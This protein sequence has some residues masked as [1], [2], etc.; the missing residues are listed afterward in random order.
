MF[1]PFSL[2]TTPRPFYH[3]F[4]RNYCTYSAK[5]LTLFLF[6]AFICFNLFSYLYFSSLAFI[7]TDLL[8]GSSNLPGFEDQS[9]DRREASPLTES[10]TWR[11]FRNAPEWITAWFHAQTLGPE[12]NASS[13][14]G[15]QD[16]Q[17]DVV[18]TWVNGS[19][20]KL[21]TLKDKYQN[22]SPFFQQYHL[23][24]RRDTLSG[25]DILEQSKR[26]TETPS[27]ATSSSSS[28]S[29]ASER[30]ND[31]RSRR[32]KRGVKLWGR[33]DQTANR[34]RDMDELKY[35]VR[36]VSQYA[37]GMFNKIHILTT[38]VDPE[39][40]ENQIPTWLDLTRSKEAIQL[41]PHT[42]IFDD[43]QV[44]PSFN[45]LSIE[46]QIHHTPGVTDV[47]L[48]L[49][50]DV[51]LGRTMAAA[52][53]WT[54]LYG[55]V[56]HM[57]PSLLVPP[58]IL[59]LDRTSLSVGEWNSLQYS[60]FLLSKQ[61]GFRH[62]AY[63]AHV[64]HVL[65]VPML[66]EIQATWPNEIFSTSSHRFR[67][68]GEALDIQVSF[69]MAHY[70]LEKLRETQLSSFWFHRLD[71]NQ[72]GI[73]DWTEREQF[74]HRLEAW[75]QA[76]KESSSS[77]LYASNF[78]SF[79]ENYQDHLQQ[80]GYPTTGSTTYHQS[81]LDGYPFMLKYPNATAGETHT[82]KDR[83][84]Y[85]VYDDIK[86]RFCQ[87]DIDYCLGPDFSNSTIQSMDNNASKA[88]FQQMAFT[89]FQ[90]G[91]CLLHMLRQTSTSSGL[92]N[93]ILPSDTSSEAYKATIADL[94]KYNYVMATSPYTFTQ[95]NNPITSKTTLRQLLDRREME[96][97]FCINDNVDNNPTA[98]EQTRDI[99]KAFLEERFSIPSPWEMT[100]ASLTNSLT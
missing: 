85:T 24:N 51:F 21:L 45:S 8:K 72:D 76:Q 93:E 56:F 74:L 20:P 99:F 82:S 3:A 53:I 38:V 19:D 10:S 67:G 30:E 15:G 84:P 22:M 6:I 87:I 97:F 35:S 34:Y 73:L 98:E 80:M 39:R 94:M 52:D 57:E 77:S 62:R 12:L 25:D 69:F 54:P 70:V 7:S 29:S 44:L 43:P 48:Y 55:F 96:T 26:W 50:D 63:L 66:Q 71:V 75:N 58:A 59:P 61:F 33:E 100:L 4:R 79:V 60:N 37:T 31:G 92:A 18:Y 14:G 46:S 17:I 5:T 95:L 23:H 1:T 28:S 11:P 9:I 42:D 88:T 16:L 49:N 13:D 86:G 78:S 64:P 27:T 47:F 90:C 89:K 36:S 2:S 40:D 65:S 81:G 83:P 41:V 32:E 68:E 91:D